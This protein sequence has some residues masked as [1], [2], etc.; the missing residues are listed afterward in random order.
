MSKQIKQMQMDAMKETF[1]DVRDLVVM[2]ASGLAA[3]TENTLRLQFRKKNI[4]MHMVK[5]SLARRVFDELQI[6]FKSPW[7]GPTLLAWGGD[8]IAELSKTLDA[9]FKKNDKVKIKCAVAEGMEVTFKQAL[10]MPTRAEALGTILAMILSPAR[11]IAGQIIG[12]ASQI[13]GQIKTLSEK[14][15]EEGAPA[16]AAPA[17]A[18]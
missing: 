12:P 14:K 7:A 5:N 16:E 4:R 6:K 8:S 3:H 1:K 17:A 9:A 11:Q 13:A 10:E 2:S 18:G 15:P